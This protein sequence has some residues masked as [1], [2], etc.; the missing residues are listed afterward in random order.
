[1]TGYRVKR[2]TKRYQLHLRLISSYV[3]DK[4][5]GK[6][7]RQWKIF[8]SYYVIQNLLQPQ[9]QPHL[10]IGESVTCIGIASNETRVC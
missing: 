1:M 10:Q 8:A 2:A 6:L 3:V 9:P 7:W 5:L 4:L